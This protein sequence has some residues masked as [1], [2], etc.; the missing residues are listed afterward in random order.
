[1][2]HLANIQPRRYRSF[3]A[4][5]RTSALIF[6]IG[7]LPSTYGQGTEHV[8]WTAMSHTAYAITGDIESTPKGF[9]IS[10]ND[11]TLQLIRKFGSEEIANAAKM[12]SMQ[13]WSNLSGGLYRTRLS[14]STRLV[15]GNTFCGK[16]DTTWIVVLISDNRQDL[17][18]ANFSGESEPDLHPSIIAQSTN[19]CGTYWYQRASA[20]T[21]H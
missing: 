7:A 14:S 10:G 15:N 8:R 16:D 20:G 17:H 11:L 19:S 6:V 21:N 2:T 9:K 13:S 4:I 18:I 12:F 5:C 1:M 3:L